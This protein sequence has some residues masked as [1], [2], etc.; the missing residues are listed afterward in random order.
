MRRRLP[1]L[2]ALL[3]FDAAARHGNFTRAAEELS[4]AQPAVTRHIAKLEDWIGTSLFKRRG[5]SI[6]LTVEGQALADVSITI[7]DR[8]ELGLRDVL[9]SNEQ[10]ILIGA[11]FG[12]AHL[13]LMPRISGMRSAS[14]ATVNFLTSDDYRSFDDPSVDCSI[15]FG[16]GEFGSYGCDFL[17]QERC[18]IIASPAFLDAHPE[19]DPNNPTQ[20]V[21]TKYMFDHG[22]PHANGWTT[23]KSLYERAG[24]S[25]PDHKR[26]ATVLSYPTMLDMVCGGEGLGIGY[27][28]II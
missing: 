17:F 9:A 5:S 24:Q 23:W 15:R 11:S 19:F 18:Q 10:E 27:W 7:F 8:L 14:N 26:L 6:E 3:A 20:T 22:D 2:N 13:W 16:N 4:V 21:D 1:P 25:L 28:T 12:V